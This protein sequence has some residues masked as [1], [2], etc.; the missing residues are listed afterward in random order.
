MPTTDNDY[1]MVRVLTRDGIECFAEFTQNQINVAIYR[2]NRMDRKH[3]ETTEAKKG[4]VSRI[5]NW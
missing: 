3:H 4:F 2:A 5:F 1:V